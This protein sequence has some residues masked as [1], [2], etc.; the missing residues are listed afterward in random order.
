MKKVLKIIGISLALLFLFRGFIYRQA[1]Y[2]TPIKTK[3]T[4]PLS[5]KKVIAKIEVAI[6]DRQLDLV[7]IAKIASSLTNNHLQF[8]FQKTSN[9]PNKMAITQKANCAAYAAF[10]NAITHHIIHRK[11]LKDRYQA[12]HLVGKI[13]FFNVNLHQFFTDTFYQN[14]DYNVIEDKL[15]GKV[16]LIDPSI[17]DYL[18][19][20]PQTIH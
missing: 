6:K 15:T 11:R 8:T 19:L 9:N 14:H 10:F 2:Y 13:N 1:I 18:Y 12:K 4:I 7:K 17:D 16:L 20:G 5:N 3:Q